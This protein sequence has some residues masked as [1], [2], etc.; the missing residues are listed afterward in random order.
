MSIVQA[1]RDESKKA[2][3][4]YYTGVSCAIVFDRQRNGMLHCELKYDSVES[5]A[6]NEKYLKLTSSFKASR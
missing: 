2:V 3:R 6:R 4:Y 1:E 5:F